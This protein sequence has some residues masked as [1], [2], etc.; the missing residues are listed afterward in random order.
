MEILVV[1]VVIAALFLVPRYVR[2]KRQD[3]RRKRRD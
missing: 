2:T 3:R 1:L